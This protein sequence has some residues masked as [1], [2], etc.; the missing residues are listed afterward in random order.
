MIIILSLF[1][2]WADP[3]Y[4]FG[5]V[6]PKVPEKTSE[7]TQKNKSAFHSSYY[8][9]KANT[10]KNNDEL[11]L[12]L[13]F[14]KIAATLSPDDVEIVG[15]ISDLKLTIDNK[16]NKHFKKGKMPTLCWFKNSR[17]ASST[18]FGKLNFLMR[19]WRQKV[20]QCLSNCLSRQPHQPGIVSQVADHKNPGR[21]FIV[22]ISLK[23]PQHFITQMQLGS[24]LVEIQALGFSCRF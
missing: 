7:K 6:G 21:Q 8:L 17:P 3:P 16:S 23:R 18:Y 15:K 9:K 10:Y 2:G 20:V 12:A 24:N 13:L 22:I 14:L 5:N 11:Q 1:F 4:S 19:L